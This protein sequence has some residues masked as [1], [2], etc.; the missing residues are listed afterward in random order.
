MFEQKE[1]E[2]MQEWYTQ[3]IDLSQTWFVVHDSTVFVR[4]NT[5]WY[6]LMIVFLHSS[7]STFLFS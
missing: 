1:S 7:V 3:A 2:K 6:L 4:T 5:S